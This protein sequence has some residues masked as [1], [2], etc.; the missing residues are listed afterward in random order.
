MMAKEIQKKPG[1]KM[2]L[3]G[4][5]EWARPEET[6]EGRKIAGKLDSER[7]IDSALTAPAPVEYPRNSHYVNRAGPDAEIHAPPLRTALEMVDERAV[8]AEWLRK[9]SEGIIPSLEKE[10]GEPIQTLSGNPHADRALF[11]LSPAGGH[12]FARA[13]GSKTKGYSSNILHGRRD[14][15]DGIVWDEKP[16]FTDGISR[17]D[18]RA[19]LI[20]GRIYFTYA[21]IDGKDSE[22]P[23][24]GL[25][26]IEDPSRPDKVREMGTIMRIREDGVDGKDAAVFQGDGKVHVLVRLKPGIQVVSFKDMSELEDTLCRDPAKRDAFWKDM[27]A[28]Y[29]K[30]PWKYNH[31]H[32]N[33]PGMGEWRPKWRAQFRAK[34]KELVNK[35]GESDLY[36]IDL[37]SKYWFGTGNPPLKVEHKGG[38]YWLGFHHWGQVL[39]DLT[40]D[41]RKEMKRQGRREESLKMYGVLATLHDYKD[42][43]KIVA[44]SPT[45]ISTPDLET[46]TLRGKTMDRHP[47]SHRDAVPFVKIVSGAAID[48]TGDDR[49]VNLYVGVNDVYTI[50]EKIRLGKLMDWM[51][52]YGR[53]NP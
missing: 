46:E 28:S 22:D 53:Y 26:V 20:N 51:L 35:Y 48:G 5:K 31:L 37:D 2:I 14:T 47:L 12:V 13:I 19:S 21:R 43:T 52:E 3:P 30:D 25:A 29:L 15:G 6:P 18:P 44:V 27:R 7:S 1:P 36:R 23:D 50:P 32:D 40:E 24:V 38:K 41:G 17:E 49:K 34:A 42:L 45:P 9:V 10:K 4:S 11:M 39:G 8:G 33:T 16:L